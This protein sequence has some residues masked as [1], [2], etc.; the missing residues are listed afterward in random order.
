LKTRKF[1]LAASSVSSKENSGRLSFAH[2]VLM[3]VLTVPTKSFGQ[4]LRASVGSIGPEGTE[5]GKDSELSCH[6]KGSMEQRLVQTCGCKGII[7]V[8]V[9]MQWH[10]VRSIGIGKQGQS[11]KVARWRA[12]TIGQ[13]SGES[14]DMAQCI[15]WN[16]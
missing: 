4:Q 13:Y 16:D 12:S 7:T 1:R 11:T 15:P 8:D 9:R 3:I 5:V 14:V 6:C 2:F 10:S